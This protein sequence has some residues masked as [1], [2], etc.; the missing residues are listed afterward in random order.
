MQ[1]PPTGADE[2]TVMT[3]SAHRLSPPIARPLTPRQRLWVALAV[4]GLALTW[5]APATLAWL[6]R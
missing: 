2:Y 1:I 6:G 4:A 3:T 5:S